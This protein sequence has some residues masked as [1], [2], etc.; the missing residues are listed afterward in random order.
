MANLVQMC[1]EKTAQ[2]TESNKFLR[3]INFTT[4]ILFSWD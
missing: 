1:E 2:L 3:K 4:Q